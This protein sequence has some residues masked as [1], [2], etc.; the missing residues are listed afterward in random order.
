MESRYDF[1]KIQDVGARPLLQLRRLGFF[2]SSSA[3]ISVEF[4][5]DNGQTIP[6]YNGVVIASYIELSIASGTA[7]SLGAL[8]GANIAWLLEA[9]ASASTVGG[10]NNFV[11]D[12]WT[13]YSY[14]KTFGK[15]VGGFIRVL[16]GEGTYNTVGGNSFNG[17]DDGFP[18]AG[19]E[20]PSA[21]TPRTF[22]S[23]DIFAFGRVA[24]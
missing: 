10:I 11:K 12:G 13:E 4:V 3:T 8:L 5:D 9:E 2:A 18:G 20:A 1:G 22:T 19:S 23:G 17:A 15:M 6:F 14:G 24:L 7:K 16:V 21:N